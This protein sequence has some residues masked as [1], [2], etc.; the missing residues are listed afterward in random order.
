MSEGLSR[1]LPNLARKPRIL[2]CAP[3]NAATDELLQRIMDHGFLDFKVT[4]LPHNKSRKAHFTARIGLYVIYCLLP[5][6]AGAVACCIKHFA[7]MTL[8]ISNISLCFLYMPKQAA[9]ECM[10]HQ[11][12]VLMV[13]QRV[14]MPWFCCSSP[15]P[16]L[17]SKSEHQ[18]VCS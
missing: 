14:G 11:G 17:P 1:T 8:R 2:V 16:C 6:I 7:L 12:S 18:D 10:R 4:W 13:M 9:G 15:V 5:C 3:S